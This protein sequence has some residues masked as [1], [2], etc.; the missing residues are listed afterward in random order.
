M[1][2]QQ[3]DLT[4]LD[5][6]QRAEQTFLLLLEQGQLWGLSVKE[7]WAMLSAEGDACTPLFPDQTSAMAW[8][9]VHFPQARA[10]VLTLEELQHRWFGLWAPDE[11][12]L[13]LFPVVR[14][15][16]AIVVKI[17]EMQQAIA[18]EQRG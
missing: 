15:E 11:V 6:E 2:Q 14:E 13:M 16:D 4:A 9:K 1:T 7:G 10:A 12:M 5:A 3:P 18:Q 8:A 17:E